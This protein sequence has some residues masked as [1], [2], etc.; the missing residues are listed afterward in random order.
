[1]PNILL[2]VGVPGSG[3]STWANEYCADIKNRAVRVNNDEL[4]A[5]LNGG[6]LY[7]WRNEDLIAEILRGIVD[8]ALSEGWNVVID[9]LNISHKHFNYWQAYANRKNYGF[10]VRLFDPGLDKCM[11]RDKLRER[12]IGE[13]RIRELYKQF[14]DKWK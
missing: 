4:R 7:D 10:G 2:L 13:T 14:E 12:T 3:K 6:I 11:E 1:M 9:N 5:M 8:N